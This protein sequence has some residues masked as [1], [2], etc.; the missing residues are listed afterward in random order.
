MQVCTEDNFVSK[1]LN[2]P[3]LCP[4]NLPRRFL[5]QEK[6]NKLRPQQKTSLAVAVVCDRRSFEGVSPANGAHRAPLQGFGKGLK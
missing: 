3:K 1:E 5:A 4:K 2:V 6:K